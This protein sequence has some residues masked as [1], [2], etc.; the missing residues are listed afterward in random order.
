MMEDSLTKALSDVMRKLCT[1]TFEKNQAV[2]TSALQSQI[3][4]LDSSFTGNNQHD[5]SEFLIKMLQGISEEHNTA[6]AGGQVNSHHASE[7]SRP[8][9]EQ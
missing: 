2:H 7:Y 1:K 8:V 4:I 3:E 5:A 6:I 9:F